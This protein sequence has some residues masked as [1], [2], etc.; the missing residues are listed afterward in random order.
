MGT[1]GTRNKP[2]INKKSDIFNMVNNSK[3]Q[4]KEGR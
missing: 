3:I 2:V 4:I 1:A